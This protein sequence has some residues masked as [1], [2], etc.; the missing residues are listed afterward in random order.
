MQLSKALVLVKKTI[1]L[2][3]IRKGAL[4][5]QQVKIDEAQQHR[6]DRD[7]STLLRTVDCNA[8]DRTITAITPVYDSHTSTKEEAITGNVSL[9]FEVESSD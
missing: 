2:H 8:T 6:F 9:H 7:S 3:L 4:V 1:L 5:L